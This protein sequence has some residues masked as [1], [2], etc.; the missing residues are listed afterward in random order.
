MNSETELLATIQK[1]EIPPF[2]ITRIEQ[3]IRG[4][5]TEMVT[6]RWVFAVGLSIIIVLFININLIK[7]YKTNGAEKSSLVQSMNLL[8][9]HNLYK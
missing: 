9:D 1:V 8:D 2:L 7:N 6:P 5:R 3:K 4:N